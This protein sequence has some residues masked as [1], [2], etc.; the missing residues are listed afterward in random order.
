[1]FLAAASCFCRSYSRIMALEEDRST[2]TWKERSVCMGDKKTCS[3][4]GL[5]NHHHKF[6]ISFSEDEAG[7]SRPVDDR[8]ERS[9]RWTALMSHFC[10][11]GELYFLA[12][13][14]PSTTSPFGTV[15]KF[16]DPSRCSI[17][18]TCIKAHVVL[19]NFTVPIHKHCFHC[20]VCRRAPPGKCKPKPLPVKVKG[21]RIPFV[22]R[23][24]R[25]PLFTFTV[26]SQ[27][28]AW[29]GI[30]WAY[31]L[32]LL[33]HLFL[34]NPSSLCLDQFIVSPDVHLFEQTHIDS[35]KSFGNIR[36]H[37]LSQIFS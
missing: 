35:Y 4:P 18:H 37:Y 3:F 5:I 14:Y 26:L 1:M 20:N 34:I 36:V 6:I 16:M 8:V 33:F 29:F 32:I 27:T 19:F 28:L 23:E 13:A 15:F 12:T 22:P 31:F 10:S 24:R 9:P 7:S 2:G 25:S 21:K 11:A 30:L 17:T